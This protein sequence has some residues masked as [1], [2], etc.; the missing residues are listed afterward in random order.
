MVSRTKTGIFKPFE[1]IN[2]HVTTTSPL[3][4]SHV[5]SLRNPNWKE[6]IVDEYNALITTGTWVLVP[7]PANVNVVHSIWLFKHKFNA[8]G[9]LNMYKARLVANGH[10]QHRGIHCDETFSS[11]HHLQYFYSISL[12]FSTVCLYMH[13]PSDPHFTALKRILCY[14][15]G[16]LDYG[17]QLH[18]SFTTQFTDA[19]WAG[20]PITQRS[21][22]GYC[23]FLGDNLL[24]WFAKRQVT[25]SLSNDEAQYQGVAN[26]VAETA[27]ICNLLPE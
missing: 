3:P 27:W 21:T 11:V 7:R 15:R 25:L 1:H 24:S 6:A 12:L 5:H 18:V 2:C 13:D 4:R 17:R 20:Y 23:L 14:V 9:S 8:D 10:S 26:V 19:D 16:T 22:S